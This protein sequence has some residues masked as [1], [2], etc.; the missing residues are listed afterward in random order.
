[1]VELFLKEQQEEWR[2]VG[3]E[4]SHAAIYTKIFFF[5]ILSQSLCLL[6]FLICSELFTIHP[7]ILLIRTLDP[8]SSK[9]ATILI[10][11]ML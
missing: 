9:I 7:Q 8:F 3:D 6:F 4:G 10:H 5:I 11:Q 1:M 2:K